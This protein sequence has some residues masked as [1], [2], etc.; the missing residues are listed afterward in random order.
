LTTRQ[1]LLTNS[2]RALSEAADGSLWIGSASGG[3]NRL[4]NGVM[5]AYTTRQGLASDDVRAIYH[6]P[7]GSLW[8]GTRGGGL[9]VFKA[10]RFTT[11]TAKDGLSSNTVFHIHRDRS[12]A[13]WLAAFDGGLVRFEDGRF[14]TYGVADGL[15]SNTV[16]TLHEDRDGRGDGS[17]WIGTKGG[18]ARLK[19]GRFSTFT[20][21][22]GLIDDIIWSILED[23]EGYLWLTCNKGVSRVKKSELENLFQGRVQAI[24]PVVYT[25]SDGLKS[26]EFSA[27]A[28]PVSWKARDGRLLFGTYKGLAI[29]DPKRIRI[30]RTPP[31]VFIEQ[32]FIDKRSVDPNASVEL[33]P[34]RGEL[35]FWYTALDF[36]APDKVRFKYELEGF[37][38]DWVDAGSRRTAYFTNIPPGHYRFRVMARNNDGV[39]N[40]AGDSIELYLKPHFYQTGWWY[41]LCAVVAIL[42]VAAGDRVRVARVTAREKELARRVDERTQELQQEI[43]ERRMAESEILLQKARFQ[44]L[45]ENAPI[46]IVQLDAQDRV[47]RTNRSFEAI[48]GY[49]LKEICD[50][51]INE[52]IVPDQF[53]EEASSISMRTFE[54]QTA[55]TTS[56][57]RRR[58]GELVPVEIYGVPIVVDR[59]HEGT[60]GIY[61]DVTERKRAEQEILEA[62]EAAEEARAAAEKARETAE[63]ANRAKSE[64]LANMSHEIRT[65][66]NGVLG[67]TAL[68][69]D[70][71]LDPVQR[72]YLEMA[73]ASADNLLKVI[74]DIL[75]FSKI[76]AGQIDLDSIEFDVRESVGLT[77]KTLA[78]RA[79]EKGLELVCDVAD[80][81]PDRLVGDPHRLSQIVIN[82]LG[83]AIK[84]TESGHVAVRVGLQEPRSAGADSVVL[85]MTVEDSGV[86]IA[87][88][89]Q[90]RIFEAFKQ[91][92]GSTTRRYGGTGLGLSISMRLVQRMSGRLWVESE[93]GRG[94]TFHFTLPLGVAKATR[95]ETA[96]AIGELAGL[97][98]LVIDDNATNRVILQAMLGRWR[99][100]STAADGGRQGLAALEAA[101][102]RGDPFP[103]VLLDAHMPDMDGFAVADEIRRRPELA[104]ATI[105]ML[106]SED[107]AGDAARCRQLGVTSYLIKP[108]APAE[109]LQAIQTALAHAMGL[110]RI[111]SRGRPTP[112]ESASRDAVGVRTS[113]MRPAFTGPAPV[114]RSLPSARGSSGR[115]QRIL[116]AEDNHVNQRLA[117]AL[118]QRDGHEV[119]VV[120]NGAAAVDAATTAVPPFDI[121]LMDVQMPEMSGF[122][123]TEAIRA[124][125]QG[126][127]S[128]VFIIAMTAHAMQGDRERCLGAGMDDYV[129]KPIAIDT[130]RVALDRCPPRMDH[131]RATLQA[132][133]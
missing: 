2:V 118:L 6:D 16:F 69:L 95:D 43:T 14:T 117:L 63:A 123:A 56:A 28:Q 90:A 10:G 50:R 9:S 133:G 24:S 1:G 44:Q 80:G 13:L 122:E 107:R 45:F 3:L 68:V 4:E 88:A 103:L 94:S 67:M 62:K 39:W 100:M 42:M 114:P 47:M 27:V 11:Y 125:E 64:F 132:A 38:K 73:K 34:G 17:L 66:M 112:V 71:D 105:L 101:V 40:E 102:G 15:P 92:D 75:D 53:M 108:I 87:P 109:L 52:V 106:T 18:L 124:H 8:V 113:A 35:E 110:A 29:I 5:T 57:R 85:H 21:K 111:P 121:I 60:Y 120:D 127:R 12:G 89:H 55:Q 58:D 82:L 74:N 76:E 25:V 79:H 77:A 49:S 81:V 97:P 70:T 128:H 54:G 46:G 91:A 31:P 65:P 115:S 83:N 7:D 99:M 126:T 116:L 30:N 59:E 32:V 26:H 98:V 33:P 78:V 131:T 51:R 104:G 41:A 129:A 37:D 119:T 20:M 93:E 61:V 86:G 84:F 22:Q 72:E 130:L 36:T 23:D 19:D 96:V 48:F